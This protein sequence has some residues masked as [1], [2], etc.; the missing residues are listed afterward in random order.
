MPKASVAKSTRPSQ[1]TSRP[2]APTASK[3]ALKVVLETSALG[4]MTARR[5]TT[6]AR[7]LARSFCSGAPYSADD[8]MSRSSSGAR[9]W[10]AGTTAPPLVG[11][12][13]TYC[14]IDGFGG[15][16]SPATASDA[17]TSA[18]E[19]TAHAMTTPF[20]MEARVRYQPSMVAQQQTANVRAAS[21]TRAL[22]VP[23][24]L[25]GLA[26][27]GVTFWLAYENGS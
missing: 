18:V 4:S 2:C 10:P 27:A 26:A 1:P 11:M 9:V 15:G 14:A 5:A 21:A 22:A 20:G 16:C 6:V 23:W 19:N 12:T 24:W 25:V 17:S 8:A 7:L 13:S 3:A